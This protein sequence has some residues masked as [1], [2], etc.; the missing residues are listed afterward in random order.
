MAGA[1]MENGVV[2]WCIPQSVSE[3]L[4][5]NCPTAA[6]IN[7]KR[8]STS[9]YSG[10]AGFAPSDI[11]I[12]R[13]TDLTDSSH[14]MSIPSEIAATAE[15]VSRVYSNNGIFCLALRFQ[16]WGTETVQTEMVLKMLKPSRAV[17]MT[18]PGI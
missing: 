1:L 11:N 6:V 13:E 3:P 9:V 2:D 14:T 15:A 10:Y 16:Q 8:R 18:A 17:L 5:F 4:G 7:L 12:V